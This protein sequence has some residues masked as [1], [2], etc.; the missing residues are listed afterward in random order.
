MRAKY[1]DVTGFVENDQVKIGYEVFGAEHRQRTVV[2][3]PPATIVQSAA[4]KAQVPYLARFARVV[5]YDPRGNGRSDRPTDSAQY[6]D[7]VLMA[8]LLAV[9]DQT[10]VERALL[11]GLCSSSWQALLTA[12][13]HPERVVGVVTI[14]TWC[15]HLTA[16]NPD[17]VA[18]PWGQPLDTDEGWAK[19]NKFYWQHDY[20]GY[21]DFF[22]HEVNP[23]PHSS[24]VVEDC[25]GWGAQT[26]PEVMIAERGGPI[27]ARNRGETEALLR[28]VGCP[29]LTIHG[30]L[31][32]CTPMSRSTCVAEL[33][34]GRAVRLEGAGHLPQARQPVVVNKLLKGF[35]DELLPPA[36]PPVR[37]WRA[38]AVRRPR[39]LFLSSPIGLG[40]ARRDIAIAK[41]LREARPDV[42]I[43]WLTQHPVTEMLERSGQT[44]HPG[45]AHLASESA[46]IESLCG[47]HDL[48]AFQAIRRMDEIFVNN[49]MLFQ[50]IVAD[51]AY[52]LVVGD[53]AWDVDHFLH[54]N[55]ELKRTAFAWLTDFVGW[56]PFDDGGAEEAW[57]A[58][59]YNAEM[60]EHVARAPRVRDV[61]LF[62]GDAAD[63]LPAGLGA[64]L[65][66]IAEW[67]TQ[68][69]DF[70]GYVT[71]DEPIPPPDVAGVREE[72]GY[73]P[74]ERVCIV[75]VGGSAVGLHLLRRCLTAFPAIRARIPGL[76]MVLVTGPRIP[77]ELLGAERAPDGLEVRGYVHDLWRHLAV[78]DVAVV[79]GGLTTTMELVAARRPFVYVPLGHHFEQQFHVAHRLDRHRAGRRLDFA[80]TDPDQL[81][82]AIESELTRTI[83][84][85]P[86]PRGA[87]QRIADR[88]S[89]LL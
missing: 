4:W 44:V 62:V 30:T 33:T 81:A 11:V 7:L 5:T 58:R 65:P 20:P 8:D 10:G 45:A 75:S 80:D 18:Y 25:I 79:Q 15:P 61:S 29:V 66:T 86:V 76:R 54:E 35:L 38:A 82:A 34:G 63:L 19:D 51:E 23:E 9:L 72:L 64:G 89:R 24:K 14:A 36:P 16:P 3:L 12:A 83:D 69:Y 27:S 41:A 37:T 70:C 77:P 43:D 26:T 67:A 84:Y 73:R 52:D 60:I 39:A 59:D 40:H 46:H 31:D 28:R 85:L 17:R 48:H 47:E 57:L 32:R 1:P 49:F 22:F 55:P 56:V 50:D 74:G 71:S 2:L 78:C 13:H 21:L 6:A 53:E 68:Q 42:Q 88:L 87:D